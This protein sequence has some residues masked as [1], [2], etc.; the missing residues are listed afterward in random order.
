[1]THSL[2]GWVLAL[3]F[4]VSAVP[5]LAQDGQF[6][7]S[8]E[9]PANNTTVSPGQ[10]IAWQVRLTGD[11]FTLGLAGFSFDLVQT[12]SNPSFIELSPASGVPTIMAGFSRPAGISNPDVGTSPGYCGTPVGT[13]G[14]TDLL[15]IGGLQNTYG[16]SGGVFGQDFTVDSGIGLGTGVVVASG[17]FPAPSVEGTY[18]F[19]IQNALVNA[20]F[21]VNAAPEASIAL[22]VDV[23]IDSYLTFFVVAPSCDPDVNQDGV[24]DQG[25][26]EYLT[27]VVSGDEN[28]EGTNPDFNND[29]A[30][31]QGDVDALI[32][33]V[34]GGQCL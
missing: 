3:A 26:V 18:S 34:A 2:I 28:P 32:N 24:V 11:A 4:A 14:N 10:P 20:L 5:A 25:D 33:V 19:E 17:S 31:D 22:P 9:S 13:S 15:E 23:V 21:Q 8:L 30:I 29:G 12:T 7:I 27:N 1:M 6:T 16:A